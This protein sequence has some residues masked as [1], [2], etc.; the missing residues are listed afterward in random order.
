LGQQVD[1]AGVYRAEG[2][3]TQAAASYVEALNSVTQYYAGW[4]DKPLPYY[5]VRDIVWKAVREMDKKPASQMA[6]YTIYEAL[7]KNSPYPKQK[8]DA[9]LGMGDILLAQSKRDEAKAKYEKALELR[10]NYDEGKTAAEKL[11]ALGN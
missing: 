2:D 1:I 9:F 10:K 8:A 6:A 11:K 7:E 5:T 3:F 4:N